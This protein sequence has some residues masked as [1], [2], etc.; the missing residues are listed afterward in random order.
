MNVVQ[1]VHLFSQDQKFHSPDLLEINVLS[2]VVRIVSMIIFN[3]I[4]L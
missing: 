1:L 4:K 2:D 3:L